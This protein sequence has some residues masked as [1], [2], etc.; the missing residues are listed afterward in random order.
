M[1]K[2]SVVWSDPMT[3]T[4]YAIGMPGQTKLKTGSGT[5]NS[6]AQYHYVAN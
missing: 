2:P 1:R 6:L 3:L 5:Y 4:M